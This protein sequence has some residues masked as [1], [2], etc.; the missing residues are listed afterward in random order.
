MNQLISVLESYTDGFRTLI[1]DK[2]SSSNQDVKSILNLDTPE[3]WGFL[4]ASMDIIEDASLAIDNFRKYGLGG[5]TKYEDYGEKYLRLYGLLNACYLQQGAIQKLC[6]IFSIK[7]DQIYTLEIRKLRNKL[8]AHSTDFDNQS[9]KTKEAYSPIRVSLAGF[10]CEYI[11]KVTLQSGG[12][13]LRDSLKQ[14]LNL[15]INSLDK[16][17]EKAVSLFYEGDKSKGEILEEL[18]IQKNG[19]FVLTIPESDTKICI[20]CYSQ[21]SNQ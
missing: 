13:D 7:T 10:S 19:G 21:T 9:S 12:T 20:T 14:H 18:R 16:I 17:F 11:N 4:C 1:N 15:I 8:G 2:I 6:K 3:D 5:P